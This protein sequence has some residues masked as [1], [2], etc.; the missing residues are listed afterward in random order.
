MRRRWIVVL[1]LSTFHSGAVLADGAS[2]DRSPVPHD[3]VIEI[4][5]DFPAYRFWLVSQRGVEPLDPA[6]GRPLLVSGDGRNGSH[7]IANIVAAPAELGDEIG[8]NHLPSGAV[9]SAEI[10]FRKYVPFYD[11]R[12]RV[13][14]RYRLDFV[15]GRHVRLIQTDGNRSQETGPAFFRAFCMRSVSGCLTYPSSVIERTR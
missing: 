14:V 4:D 12:E 15:P 7:R 11:S 5:S 1:A 13:V 10:D 8:L 6:P 2:P 9:R 3:L